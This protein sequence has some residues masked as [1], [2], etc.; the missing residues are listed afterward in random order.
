[1]VSL[2]LVLVEDIDDE[3]EL[4]SIKAYDI[5]AHCYNLS[6]TLNFGKT[7]DNNI[8]REIKT[9]INGTIYEQIKTYDE[10][11]AKKYRE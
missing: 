4:G 5:V 2:S 7:F 10:I 9:A 11:F 1:M 3:F 6:I 8:S